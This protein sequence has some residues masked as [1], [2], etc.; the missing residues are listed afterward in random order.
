MEA[1]LFYRFSGSEKKRSMWNVLFPF[2]QVSLFN[3]IV[4]GAYWSVTFWTNKLFS[5]VKRYLIGGIK[6]KQSLFYNHIRLRATV[7]LFKATVGRICTVSRVAL[8]E[9]DWTESSPS[10]EISYFNVCSTSSPPRHWMSRSL[11]TDLFT[12]AS[13]LAVWP[14]EWNLECLAR[15]GI[16]VVYLE[17]ASSD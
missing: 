1:E 10:F 14:L 3:R 5:Q 6:S 9:G 16:F 13:L 12:S 11:V 8:A 7:A 2:T 4:N 15:C 17:P